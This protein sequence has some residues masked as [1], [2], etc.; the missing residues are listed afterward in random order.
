MRENG[1][2]K[3]MDIQLIAN[4]AGIYL[5]MINRA[6]CDITKVKFYVD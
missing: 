6:I 5:V 3:I 4:M 2:E 1:R